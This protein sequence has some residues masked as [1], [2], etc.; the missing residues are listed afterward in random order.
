MKAL[1]IAI[2]F[3][4]A[5][6]LSLCALVSNSARAEWNSIDPAMCMTK[7]E[8]KELINPIAPVR[9]HNALEE[10]GMRYWLFIE[11]RPAP[12]ET[13]R[14][15]EFREDPSKPQEV[16]LVVAGTDFPNDAPEIIQ[17]LNEN[18]RPAAGS[19]V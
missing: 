6:L 9:M 12:G 18:G 11:D 1:T 16:C 4:A 7:E 13:P 19:D 10:D 14:F 3:A 8:A 15:L 17:W 2:L 5:G